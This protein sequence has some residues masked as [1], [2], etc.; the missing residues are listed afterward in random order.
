ME[1]GPIFS[2]AKAGAAGLA[3]LR[4]VAA[5]PEPR[6]LLHPR[7]EPQN[8][9]PV[10]TSSGEARAHI[11]KAER[12]CPGDNLPP[13]HPSKWQETTATSRGIPKASK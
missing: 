11:P 5:A 13:L 6:A 7:E 1:S 8:K 12:V 9:Y 2:P 3:P 10:K 4:V